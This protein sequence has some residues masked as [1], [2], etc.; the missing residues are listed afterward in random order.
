MQPQRILYLDQNAW[1]ALAKGVWDRIEY[2]REH[3]ALS[4]VIEALHSRGLLVPLS[5][6][7]IYETAKINDPSRRRHLAIVQSTISG[8]RVFRSRSRILSETLKQY[9]A[10]YFSLSLDPLPERWFLSDL[11]F[12]AAAECSAEQYGF[13]ISDQVLEVVRAN[14]AGAL[15]DYLA[16]GDE[17]I[18]VE[19]VRLFSAS[20]ANLLA[21][22]KTSRAI[23]AGESMAIRRQV[24]RAR[25]LIEELDF[26]IATGHRLGLQWKSMSD[27]RSSLARRLIVKLP[28]LNIERELV[29]RLEDQTRPIDENDLRDMAS[30]TTV[31][32][33][34][35]LIVAENL[36][37]NLARQAR[38]G[39]LYQTQL[40]TSVFELTVDML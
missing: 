40:L 26:V 9:L 7:N 21:R 22:L 15:F 1:I 5:Y 35:D 11:W 20:S 39:V 34:A 10:A 25:L 14:P 4:V 6:A 37:V 29:I 24:Y 2:P 32:P 38:L 36:F 30:F 27:I 16:A 12:E 23:V 8:G 28:V 31:L 17:E 3:A 19:A 13:E 33:F 18:R